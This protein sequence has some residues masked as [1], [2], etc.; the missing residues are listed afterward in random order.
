MEITQVQINNYKSLKEVLIPFQECGSYS[1]KS[2][3]CFFVGLNETGKSSILEALDIID[4]DFSSFDYEEICFKPALDENEYVELFVD[5]EQKMTSWWIKKMQET[6]N[7]PEEIAKQITFKTLQKNIYIKD[8]SPNSEYSVEI[9]E[10]D[11]FKYLIEEDEIFLIKERNEITESITK[12]NSASF[13]KENQK[14]LDK[15]TLEGII[16]EKF[17]AIFDAN[18]PKVQIWKPQK[19]FLINGAIDL[20]AFKDSTDSHIPLKNIFH[21]SGFTNDEAIKKAIERALKNQEKTD[22]L[23]DKLSSATTK[24]INKIWKEH[25]IKIVVSINAGN[26]QVF[27]E[28]K[29]KKHSYFRMEQRSDGFQQF[30]SLILSLSAQNDSNNLKN[31]VILIDEPEVHLHP[32]GV[33]YMRDEILK[34]GKNNN[35]FVATHSHYMVDTNCQE[36][37]WIVKKEKAETSISQIDENTPIEDD[38]VLSSAFG[39]NLFKELLPQYILIVEGGDDKHIVQHILDKLDISLSYSIKSAGGA[40]KAPGIA[41]LLSN[42]EVPA[43]VLFDDDKEGRDNRKKIFDNFKDT[44]NQDNVF[45]LR[46]LVSSIPQHSTMEDMMPTDYVKSFFETELGTTFSID[47]SKA[48]IIQLKQQSEAL[49]NKQ[50]L[51]SLKVKLSKKFVED[52]TTKTKIENDA[53]RMKELVDQLILKWTN[54]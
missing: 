15:T 11:L 20:N 2:N 39:L 24:H 49:K 25:K 16:T 29:D 31:K 46:D 17:T 19:E 34:I 13:L 53:P 12:Q 41:S 38:D 44:Y 54:E 45:T 43:F 48:I 37:H 21:I 36:R 35:V 8:E 9:E 32:S 7:I 47:N 52:F 23:K 33:R 28:D 1:N 14:L 40:S 22:E 3:A 5:F 4:K 6:C 42:E 50:K 27:V 10:I 26:C 30:V 18:I 51:E